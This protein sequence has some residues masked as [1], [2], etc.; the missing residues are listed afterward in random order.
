MNETKLREK[1]S[2]IIQNLIQDDDL[3]EN[4]W[5]TSPNDKGIVTAVKDNIENVFPGYDEKT[6]AFTPQKVID[7]TY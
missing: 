5:H 1:I 3:K 7:K 2:Y 6:G 4:I